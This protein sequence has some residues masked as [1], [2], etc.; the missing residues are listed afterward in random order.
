VNSTLTV[1]DTTSFYESVVIVGDFIV[2]SG[3]EVQLSSGSTITV[4]GCP[5]INGSLALEL[6]QEEIDELN[7][8]GSLNRTALVYDVTCSEGAEFNQV[9]IKN[10]QGKEF[11]WMRS[12]RIFL[13]TYFSFAECIRYEATQNKYPGTITILVQVTTL[14]CE[15]LQ[16]DGTTNVLPDWAIAVIV[17]GG[18]LIAGGAI[19]LG[20]ALRQKQLRDEMGN[21]D[22]KQSN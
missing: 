4:L 11:S 5:Q 17:V 6:T 9:V 21:L 15:N 20:V 18:L 8:N 7:E 22:R 1:N 3:T 19:G 2:S 14:S 13:L 12:K 10:S 16:P